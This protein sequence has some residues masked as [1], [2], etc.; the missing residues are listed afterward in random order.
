[1]GRAYINRVR[2]RHPDVPGR[3]D[4]CVYWFR[5]AHDQLREGDHAGLVGT[6]T[7]RQNYSREGGLDHIV[8]SGGTIT[9]AVSSQVWSGDSVVHVSIV[10]WKKGSQDGLKNLYT[11]VGDKRDSPWQVVE[12]ES[13]NSALSDSFDVTCAKT[14]RANSESDTCLQGQTHGHEGFLLDAN[15]AVGMISDARLNSDVIFPY[16]TAD[17]LLG[18]KP[19][20]PQRY[21]IDFQPRDLFE[22]SKYKLPFA[23]VKELVLPTRQN[24][25]RD[26]LERN[27][28][29]QRDNQRAKVNRHHQNFLSRWWLLS[30]GRAELVH[31]ALEAS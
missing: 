18:S 20:L 24:A 6:N 25:A 28:E 21:V 30:Y 23:R 22:A 8:D 15:D 1:M 16:L 14:L 5:K 2:A 9:E 12:L 3:A 31:I 13:I 27:A 19:T 10:N 26:E 4:Y 11:Q 7:I 17:E 29:A